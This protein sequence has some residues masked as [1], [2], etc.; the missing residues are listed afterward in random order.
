MLIVSGRLY[1]K[2]GTRDR[3]LSSCVASIRLARLAHGC[4]DFSVSADP[5]DPDRA[6]VYEAWT[7]SSS[8]LTF[9]EGSAD[10]PLFA[11]IVRADV[12]RHEV[13]SSGPP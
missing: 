1:L 9:R 3:F 13:S 2:P 6:N 7:D 11:L 4:L 12:Q 10:D 8:L 5:I